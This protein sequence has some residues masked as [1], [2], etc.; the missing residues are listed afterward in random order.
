MLYVYRKKAVILLLSLSKSLDQHVHLLCL[1]QL[2]IESLKH[3]NYSIEQEKSLKILSS[4]L[5]NMKYK[6]KKVQTM[7]YKTLH[8]TLNIEKY[9]PTKN[10]E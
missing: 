7:I 9:E 10:L 5:K 6:E 3:I 4:K 8:R 2:F 1:I